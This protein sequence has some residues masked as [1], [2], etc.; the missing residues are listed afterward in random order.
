MKHRR[1][2]I[3]GSLIASLIVGGMALTPNLHAQ[4]SPEPQA[5]SSTQQEI[6]KP[7]LRIFKTYTLKYIKPEEL[8]KATRI[9]LEDASYSDNMVTVKIW[10]SQI[11][12]FEE[13]LKKLDVEKKSIQFQA[14]AIVA[15]RDPNAKSNE[16]INNKELNR[17]L[18]ELKALWNFKTYRVEG[19]SFLTVRESS[20][21]NS[22]ELVTDRML[23]LTIANAKVAGEEPGKRTITIEELKLT[24]K[25]GGPG[26]SQPFDHE[27][28]DTRDVTLKEKGYL[29][30]GVSGY[31]SS[32]SYALI[33]V[34]N[35]EIK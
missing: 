28:I 31:G 27:L 21:S 6:P 12:S 17:V 22:I 10:Q 13:M 1:L 14:F 30:A 5:Q 18:D 7:N 8:L 11:P 34:I 20:G 9:L 25:I 33:L 32:A 35:A 19:P 15:S 4:V 29:V 16:A 23:N 2:L 3:S 26:E 24:E